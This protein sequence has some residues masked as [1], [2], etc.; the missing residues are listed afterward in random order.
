MDYI[1]R[2]GADDDKTSVASSKV[3]CEDNQRALVGCTGVVLVAASQLHRVF[4]VILDSLVRP[5]HNDGLAQRSNALKRVPLR[6]MWRSPVYCRGMIPP[7][8][9]WGAYAGIISHPSFKASKWVEQWVTF[10]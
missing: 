5:V 10:L 8:W 7:T 4:A 2:F 9:L 1:R 3:A 6:L